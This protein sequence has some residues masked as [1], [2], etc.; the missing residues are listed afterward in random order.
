MKNPRLDGAFR[1]IGY[2]ADIIIT[3]VLEK[4]EFNSCSVIRFEGFK[5]RTNMRT[6]LGG[7][8]RALQPRLPRE[9]YECV[10]NGTEV[11]ISYI[12]A[13]SAQRSTANGVGSLSN[14]DVSAAFDVDEPEAC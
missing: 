3:Q 13:P 11:A 7:V 8:Q 12:V 6:A 2:L 1:D 10:N 14:G 5:T 9:P 4:R